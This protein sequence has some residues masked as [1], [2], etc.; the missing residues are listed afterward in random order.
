MGA[1]AKKLSRRLK[2]LSRKWK[3]LSRKLKKQ[4]SIKWKRLSRKWKNLKSKKTK[5]KRKKSEL[6]PRVTNNP[7][8]NC[9]P[10]TFEDRRVNKSNYSNNWLHNLF[11][12]QMVYILFCV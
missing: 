7:Y 11:Y 1:Q 8:I 4:L 10:S 9:S 2:K 5:K 6:N 12:P 3:K